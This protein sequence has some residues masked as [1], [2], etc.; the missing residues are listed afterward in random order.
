MKDLPVESL[1]LF[2]S[3]TS[4][5]GTSFAALVVA[6]LTTFFFTGT[7]FFGGVFFAGVFFAI[8]PTVALVRRGQRQP[9]EGLETVSLLFSWHHCQT[10]LKKAF[11][12]GFT[13]RS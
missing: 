13:I 2:G 12:A 6:V 8:A 7:F 1:P 4:T 5:T 11:L 10:R 9:H 3:S